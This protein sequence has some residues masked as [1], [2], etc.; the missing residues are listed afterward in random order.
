MI[1]APSISLD[2]WHQD[3][4]A[5]PFQTH[6]VWWRCLGN[7]GAPPLILIHGFP[8][9]SWD[10]AWTGPKLSE[11]FF[12]VMPD[13]LDYGHSIRAR[14]VA[15]DLKIQADMIE[16]L[17]QTLNRRVVGILAHDVGDSVAQELLAR[18]KEGKLPFDI[19]RI[20]FLN[21]GM[22]PH[23]HRPT[24]AQSLL[25]ARFGPLLSALLTPKKMLDGLSTVFG[26]HTKPSGSIGN[27][28][29]RAS[30]GKQGKSAFA[31]RLR[32]IRERKTNAE[33]WIGA[34]K[35]PNLPMLLVN[36]N[37]DPVSGRHAADGFAEV[38]PHASIKHLPDIGHF[39]QIEAPDAVLEAILPFF[40]P[41]TDVIDDQCH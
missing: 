22:L 25:S 10:W 26:P 37:A 19:D 16:A 5:V 24:R 23:L 20:A 15:V 34:L 2:D 32:Y 18:R 39:P 31:R 3:G 12:L 40:E 9:C 41:L 27:D 29:V 14:G 38:A 28:L 21:G 33:R 11:R 8:T 35:Q 7:P 36:G 13:L 30:L 1:Q 17:V 6:Q 4:H